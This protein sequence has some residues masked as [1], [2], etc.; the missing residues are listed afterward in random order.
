MQELLLSI[1]PTDS[2]RLYRWCKWYVDLYNGENNHHIETNGEFRFMQRNLLRC[3]TVFD[4]GA[5]MGSWASLALE[6][7]PRLQ[8][9]CFEP[10]AF[11]YQKLLSNQFPPNVVCKNLGMSSAPG[12]A[13]LFVFEDGAGI[14]SLYQRQGLESHGLS[15][16]QR[17]ETVYLSTVDIYCQENEI[18]AIDFLKVDVEGHELEVFRGMSEML[19][20][21]RVNIIQF[22]YGGCNI[23]AGVFLKDIFNFFD[24]LDYAFHK[25]Y[26]RQVKP[27]AQYD[28]R[29]D[30]FQYQNWVIVRDGHPFLP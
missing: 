7:N 12:E 13:R 4:I 24:T 22:E 18:Q 21:G 11:T 5:H 27:V 28:Q 29:L 16:Q 19:E 2:R 26:P 6:V 14:N 20:Q 9:H 3:A 8:L 25:I 23:D 15:T 30:N 1:V 17:Q 10:S